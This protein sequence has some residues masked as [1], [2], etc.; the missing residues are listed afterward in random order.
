MVPRLKSRTE[1]SRKSQNPDNGC[2]MS[3]FRTPSQLESDLESHLESLECH[4]TWDLDLSRSKLLCLRDALEDIGPELGYCWLGHIYNLQGFVHHQLGLLEDARRFLCRA[5]EAFRQLRNTVSDEGPWLVVNYGNMAWL[6]Y[7]LGEWARSRE[8]LSKVGALMTEY[9]SPS[10]DDP[11]PE[12]CA[13][14]AWTLM[15]F[16]QKLL[17]VDYFQKAIRMQPDMVEWHTSRVLAL[18][19]A[20][21]KQNLDSDI[22][23]KVKIAKQHDPENLYLVA[24]YLEA[25]AQK[26]ARIHDEAQKL[27]W[28][29][30]AKPVSSYSGVKPLLRLY[31]THVSMDE[32]VDLAEEAL[33]R[34]P[35]ARHIKK[36]AAICYKRKVFSQS[37]NHL[38]RSL[39]D[40]AISLHKQTIALYPHSSL[41]MQIS[42]ANMYVKSNQRVEAEDAFEELLRRN[43]D[44]EEEQMVCSFYAK[45][46]QYSQKERKKSVRFYMRAAAI[47]HHSFYRDDS[48]RRLERMSE[49]KRQPMSGDIED[50]LVHL[51]I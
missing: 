5:A 50:F 1:R 22:L 24:L 32:A 48:I 45:Y 10:A 51:S 46:L 31:R 28:K 30:L 20:S 37:N 43:L 26:G 13:E 40:R 38:D 35:K 39:M 34:Q 3:A 44:P 19:E 25:Q 4:F 29:V 27:A 11:H 8:Y 6:H 21:K 17:A 49:E 12:I 16:N 33:E 9:P 7:R 41:K 14:K 2:R 18:V 42:L 23:E 15:K 47:P 36:C